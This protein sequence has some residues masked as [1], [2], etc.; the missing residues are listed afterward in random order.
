MDVW[1]W[2]PDGVVRIP[3]FD[4]SGATTS[5]EYGRVLHEVMSKV[6]PASR[7]DLER[8]F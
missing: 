8:D 1:F 7:V 5:E 6:D 2:G 3:S 4:E